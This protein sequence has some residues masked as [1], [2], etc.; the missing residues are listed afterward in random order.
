MTEAPVLSRHLFY[1]CLQTDQSR[2]PRTM[3]NAK[4]LGLLF[5]HE[6]PLIMVLSLV[7]CS[8]EHYDVGTEADMGKLLR[9]PQR[10]EGATVCV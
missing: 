4:H 2:P 9:R 10:T 7:L 1:G 6:S 5:D 8:G 3:K